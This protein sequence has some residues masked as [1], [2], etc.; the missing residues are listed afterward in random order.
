MKAF[1]KFEVSPETESKILEVIE[2]AT[3]AKGVR[4]G[5]NETTKAIERGVAKLVVMA[6][7]V[8]PEEILVH[9]PVLCEEKVIPYAYVKDKL[10]L[11]KAAGLTVPTSSIAIVDAG[12]KA[13]LL[14][15]VVSGL[16]TAEKTVEKQEKKPEPVKEKKPKKEEKKKEPVKEE[17]ARG[18]QKE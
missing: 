3:A 4:K 7:N 13:N 15:E 17:K 6:E 1:V 14:K 18:E 16:P 9:V 10:A 12:I 8:E 2:S 11:G 5:M